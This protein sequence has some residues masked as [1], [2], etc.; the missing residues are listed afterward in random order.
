MKTDARGVPLAKEFAG[1]ESLTIVQI[2]SGPDKSRRQMIRAFRLT[3]KPW[4]PGGVRAQLHT[5]VPGR[6]IRDQRA[7]GRTIRMFDGGEV[8]EE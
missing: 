5:V 7:A 1:D 4:V 8:P 6:W 3:D 2:V